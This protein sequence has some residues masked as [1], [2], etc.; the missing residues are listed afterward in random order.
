MQYARVTYSG[1]ELILG[2]FKS[3]SVC[4]LRQIAKIGEHH[5]RKQYVLIPM[6]RLLGRGTTKHENRLRRLRSLFSD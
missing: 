3:I 1:V 2:L 4:N 6:P 5:Y